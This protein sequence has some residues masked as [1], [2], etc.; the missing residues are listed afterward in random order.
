MKPTHHPTICSDLPSS[1]HPTICSDLPSQNPTICSDLPHKHPTTC[2]F[3]PH[4][5]HKQ[6]RTPCHIKN[7]KW[8]GTFLIISTTGLSSCCDKT[9]ILPPGVKQEIP[10]VQLCGLATG[11]ISDTDYTEIYI[12]T[13]IHPIHTQKLLKGI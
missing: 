13:Y 11:Y 8:N 6:Q 9:G 4:T 7:F 5:I 3:T 1:Q 10:H 2:R 12:D